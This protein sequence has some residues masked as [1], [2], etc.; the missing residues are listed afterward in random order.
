MWRGRVNFTDKG[1]P[2]CGGGGLISRIKG[3]PATLAQRG[4]VYF[5]DEGHRWGYFRYVPNKVTPCGGG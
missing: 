3:N 1:Q 2:L 5:P 4:Q